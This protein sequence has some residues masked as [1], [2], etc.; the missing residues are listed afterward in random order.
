MAVSPDGQK[1]AVI[2][3]GTENSRGIWVR[4]LRNATPRLITTHSGA[5]GLFW[6]PDSSTIGF[7]A[8][9]ELKSI[10][11]TTSEIR[12]IAANITPNFRGASWNANGEI[13]Y[14]PSPRGPLYFVSRGEKPRPVFDPQQSETGGTYL[15]WPWFLPDGKHFL[16]LGD[17]SREPSNGSGSDTGLYLGT[18][19]QSR[20]RKL[21]DTGYAARYA[22]GHVL[23]VGKVLSARPF[24]LDRLDFTG[25]AMHVVDNVAAMGQYSMFG[26]GDR[27]LAYFER[28]GTND[29]R[30]VGLAWM[31][32]TGNR[33]AL[34]ARAT[35][36]AEVS[37]DG[38]AIVY[39]REGDLWIREIGTGTEWR[40]TFDPGN[41]WVP[42]WTPDS[43]S[44]VWTGA[45]AEGRWQ[46]LRK[47]ANGAGAEEQLTKDPEYKHHLHVVPDGKSVVYECG[48]NPGGDLCVYHIWRSL[49]AAAVYHEGDGD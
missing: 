38:K 33:E 15:T 47:N 31:T 27:T 37:P 29:T 49:R 22:H 3:S 11:I 6:S 35:A 5:Y 13:L 30:R 32:I 44:I 24:D 10:D 20:L 21:L 26:V 41:D 34:I 36:H 8:G 9:S 12:T 7:A 25:P 45:R 43:K 23:F 17:A 18:L 48:I 14:A 19:G 2:A 1:I 28:T 16:A 42:A 40:L 39:S 4:E 46:L